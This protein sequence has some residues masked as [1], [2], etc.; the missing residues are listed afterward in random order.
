[1]TKRRA[2]LGWRH[3][4]ETFYLLITVVF[5]LALLTAF[6]S[7]QPAPPP[8]DPG[9]PAASPGQ[10]W[11]SEPAP[12]PG[13]EM[14]NPCLAFDGGDP[15]FEEALRGTSFAVNGEVRSI[16][17]VQL[18]GL[19]TLEAQKVWDLVGGRSSGKL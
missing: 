5:L 18:V 1:M 3:V 15:L 11:E 8:P 4:H 16:E 19:K 12:I 7:A 17:E 6:A 2:G 14:T 13:Q 9:P 10:T